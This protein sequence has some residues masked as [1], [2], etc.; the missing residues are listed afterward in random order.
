MSSLAARLLLLLCL[1]LALLGSHA[2]EPEAAS[3]SA[4]TPE[5][6]QEEMDEAREEFESIDTN[7]VRRQQTSERSKACLSPRPH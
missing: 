1:A 3:P 2:A 7:M 4:H 5:H 6:T